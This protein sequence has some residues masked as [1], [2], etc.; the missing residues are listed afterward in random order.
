MSNSVFGRDHVPTR[1]VC[2]LFACAILALSLSSCS[3]I[4]YALNIGMK[5]ASVKAVYRCIPAGTPIDTPSGT[6]A[7]EKL[8]P[9]DKVI[10]YSGNPVSVLQSHAYLEDAS[11]DHFYRI[12]FNNGAKVELC[13]RHRIAGKIA[14]AFSVGDEIAGHEVVSV[15]TFGGVTQSYDLL[16]EDTGYQ[17]SGIPVNSMI[18]EMARAIRGHTVRAQSSKPA[19]R[20]TPLLR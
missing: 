12:T 5:A 17:I 10:G 14:S 16:T 11:K 8:V 6:V 7:I 15:E 1:A 19:H 2:T 20:L 18:E 3:L 13:D 9:G 4:G